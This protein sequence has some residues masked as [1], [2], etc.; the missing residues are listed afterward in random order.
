M[1]GERYRHIFLPGPDRTEGFTNPRRGGG[2]PRIPSRDRAG[3]S[4]Y[5]RGRLESAWRE[6]E[7]RC[8]VA[9]ADRHG[10]YIDF[11]SEPGFDLIIKSLESLRSGIRLLNVRRM[12]DDGGERTIATVYVPNAK[13]VHF[14]KKIRDYAEQVTQTGKPKNEKLVSSISDIRRSVLKSFWQD[15]RE[16]LPGTEPSWVEVWLSSDN[17]ETVERFNDLLQGHQ[18]DRLDGV[19]RFPE[20]A[21]GVIFANRAQLEFLIESSDDIAEFRLAKEVATFFI[22][23]E[24]QEQAERVRELLGRTRFRFDHD[25]AVTILDSGV[26]NG[27]ALLESVLADPDLHTVDPTWGTHDHGGHGTLMAG[28]AAYGDLLAILNSS[29]RVT[30]THRLESAKILPPPPEKNPKKLWG[31]MTA[32]GIHRAEIQASNRKRIA[33][34]AVTSTDSRDLGRP[35]SWSATIDELSSGYED[36]VHRLF[37]VAA[38]NTDDSDEF[39]VYPDS[40]TTNQVHDPGQSWNALTVGAFTEKVRITAPSLQ[41]YTPIAP[42]GGLSPFS[43]TSTTW[44]AR[45]WPIK[46]DVVF[47]GGNVAKG[48]NDSIIDAEDLK[49]LSTFHNPQMRHFA[50]FCATSAATAQAA[51]MAAVIQSRYPELW[52]ETIR[53]L[54]IH[55][56]EWTEMMRTQFLPPPPTQPSKAEYSKM[57]RICGYGVPNLDRALYCASNF[58]TLVCQAELQPFAEQDGSRVTKDMHF[59]KLPWPLE[60]LRDLGEVIVKMRVTLSYFV[61]PGP[62]EVG[63][64]DRYR[65]AS[66][67]LRFAV[68]GP[69]ENEREFISRINNQARD[70]G[71]HHRTE[72]P[73]DRWLI[74]EN[75]RNVGSVHS[76][77]WQGSAAELALSN[78]IGIYPAVG[79]W[80]ERHHL[81]RVEKQSRYSLLVSIQTPPLN[82]DIYT[83]VAVK[84]GIAV[85]IAVPVDY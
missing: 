23:M 56:A 5:L 25:I 6:D 35:S 72:G 57:L 58:L 10:V 80:R 16:V 47:E 11:L 21:V 55:T 81:G 51:W 44:E 4:A 28:T 83:P 84:V 43:T 64:Q 34:L 40:N 71:E 78:L 82:V 12:E 30:V 38:G 54:I 79:W 29:D 37:I 68:N 85:P 45:K 46:P 49:L 59:Y 67:A 33:C 74:G 31:Y 1:A 60:V 75:T 76:D 22:E 61:E 32:Q 52:P 3:H 70:D 2:Q 41:S 13:R 9:H 42:L 15:A 27:H 53:G 24:N 7:E 39:R 62:G 66:H 65:Y 77:I 50:P 18:I 48:P 17:D 14:L 63:W 19:V 36:G 8:A 20:R 73:G 26:N 69:G